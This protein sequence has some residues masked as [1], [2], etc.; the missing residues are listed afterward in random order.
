MYSATRAGG[1]EQMDAMDAHLSE[2]DAL[3]RPLERAAELAQEGVPK[4]TDRRL[5]A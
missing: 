1:E 5:Q 2:R 4:V 3:G